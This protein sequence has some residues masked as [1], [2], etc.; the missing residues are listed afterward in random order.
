MNKTRTFG[1]RFLTVFLALALLLT[2]VT[3]PAEDVS[4]ASKKA[5][6]SV[7]LK[8]NSKKA[9][10]KTISLEKGKNATIKVTV[11][12][13]SAKK[14]ITFKS[15]KKSVATVS[16]KGVVTAKKAGTAKITVTVTGKNKKKKTTWVKIK[17]TNPKTTTPQTPDTTT[18]G[19]TTP[20]TTTPDT[21]TPQT[22][23]TVEVTSV[24]ATASPS[25][26]I[27]V[28]GACTI[29]AS[30]FPANA[31]DKTI[32]YTS[33]NTAVAQV[34]QAGVVTGISAGTSTIRATASNGKYAEVTVTVVAVPVQ[35]ISLS[36]TTIANLS[37]NSKVTLTATVLPE[38]A[39]N[40]VVEWTSSNNAVATVNGGIVT[41]VAA[42]TATISATTKDGKTATCEVTVVEESGTNKTVTLKMANNY[43]DNSGITYPNT[44]LVG[45]GAVINIQVKKDGVPLGQEPIKLE[46]IANS[47]NAPE[48][49]EATLKSS[50]GLTRDDGTATA[51]VDLKEDYDDLNSLSEIYQN[52]TLK[53]TAQSVNEYDEISVSFA[54]IQ[55]NGITVENNDPASV[56]YGQNLIT[57][58]P[59]VREQL[60]DGISVTKST[61]IIDDDV[62]RAVDG[63]KIEYVSSQQ[64]T[65]VQDHTV[66]FDATPVLLLPAEEKG[67]ENDSYIW[68]T[69]KTVEKCHVYNEATNEETSVE[70]TD[71]PGGLQHITLY[72]NKLK[73]SKYTAIYVDIYSKN[74][75]T[76]LHHQEITSNNNKDT[77]STVQVEQQFDV[78]SRI[79]ISMVT[80]GQVD[81]SNEGY[82]LT[83]IEAPYITKTRTDAVEWPLMNAV[84]W[85]KVDIFDN[86]TS[87]EISEEEAKKYLPDDAESQKMYFS[88]DSDYKYTYKY[89]LPPF[90]KTGNAIF[91]VET[92]TQTYYLA[93]PTVKD[94]ETNV[95]VLAAP[96]KYRAVKMTDEELEET[97]TIQVTN[98][99]YG[100]EIAVNSAKPG[101][102]A[103]KA[104]LNIE[105]VDKNLLNEQ[106]N[107]ILYTSV[108]WVTE[109]TITEETPAEDYF[110]IENQDVEVT[111][112][113]YGAGGVNPA[114]PTGADLKFYYT[115]A[116]GEKVEFTGTPQAGQDYEIIG[117][118]I[119]V[120]DFAKVQTDGAKGKFKFRLHGE[121]IEYVEGIT[122]ECGNYVVKLKVGDEATAKEVEKA[123]IYWV[124]LGISYVN[125]AVNRYYTVN[126]ELKDINTELYGEEKTYADSEVPFR[127]TV[128]N[129]TN[130]D[131]I[132]ST[133][134]VGEEWEIGYQV[135]AKS[136]VFNYSNPE[137]VEREALTNEFISADNVPLVYTQGGID[138][139]K[140]DTS[141]GK[142]AVIMTKKDG[143]IGFDGQNNLISSDDAKKV[144]F[145]FYNEEGEK[146]SYNN[147]GTGEIV[148]GATG[149]INMDITWKLVG[150]KA[151]VINPNGTTIASDTDTTLYVKVT[152]E[153]GNIRKGYPVS[154]VATLNGV[155]TAGGDV[156]GE[157]GIYKIV[158]KA[159]NAEGT[160]KVDITVDGN[161]IG[162]T[163]I[164]N[165]VNIVYANAIKNGT[166]APTFGLDAFTSVKVVDT[167]TIKVY[168]TNG[169]NADTIYKTGIFELVNSKGETFTVEAQADSITN[170]GVVL[171]LTDKT[172]VYSD[173]YTLTVKPY[174]NNGVTYQL[175]DV[176]G[177]KLKGTSTTT[178]KPNDILESV[179]QASEGTVS[180]NSVDFVVE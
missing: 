67:S 66:Y 17:V 156:T 58:A 51:V 109:E 91:S 132:Q 72:F 99:T 13:A 18:P 145:N 71:V 59:K 173:T 95:N 114:E 147:V 79:V 177:Q 33:S 9:T 151:S 73:L 16:K 160:C 97:G 41:G 134:K 112:Q 104:S 28:G 8:I 146:V 122:A 176:F 174:E 162:A 53:V 35:S 11:K 179:G 135:V 37:V 75:G 80:Q 175:I 107:G 30:V 6:K 55:L 125:N 136:H 43:T 180:D 82:V 113:V 27:N 120:K 138:T 1:K 60:G 166:T 154:Y 170:S 153:N 116:S 101:R 69:G 87:K 155:S 21:T 144:V 10:K 178:F 106:K 137:S 44:V 93:Y 152:D 31:T 38:N 74:D 12:P 139:A 143:I 42:G 39:T 63:K 86:Y 148:K 78:P 5:V 142:Y 49:F 117:D 7:S 26:Q 163:D 164:T 131:V 110:A 141:N 158:L 56:H 127:T 4:A 3:I 47:G 157:D 84:T 150:L 14:K 45:T 100:N 90:P 85:E 149:I 102:T 46:L 111:A 169:V 121:N 34:N 23:S 24:A 57:P 48:C 167:T 77:S 40:P 133:Y 83:M 159:P 94:S 19:T 20:D 15:S 25:S 119:E 124:D 65:E 171:T 129:N 96:G 70:I 64:D 50:D 89:S 165:S 128:F 61:E 172:L 98:S 92:K 118:G 62:R 76:L 22:P 115:N 103:L 36:Q 108:H 68:N 140:F 2:S 123:N 52:Y 105:G 168:F 130:A 54:S 161:Q 81:T 29:V 88:N 32:T 126:G